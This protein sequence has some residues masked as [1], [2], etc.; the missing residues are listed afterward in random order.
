MRA[1]C[2]HCCFLDG[3]IRGYISC[4]Q[5]V[6]DSAK[7]CRILALSKIKSTLMRK[8]MMSTNPPMPS[9]PP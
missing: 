8:S 9:A 4:L 6:Q 7:V 1:E 5:A 3:E 2:G